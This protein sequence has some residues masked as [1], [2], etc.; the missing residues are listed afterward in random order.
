MN[1][2]L[3]CTFTTIDSVFY[4]VKTIKNTYK[5]DVAEIVV[6]GYNDNTANAVCIYNVSDKTKR[7]K[8]TISINKKKE[9]NTFY[10]INALNALIMA[11]NNGVLD[12]SYRINWSDYT[13]SILLSNNKTSYRHIQITQINTF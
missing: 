13:N 5:Q 9:T 6:Y 7:L 11:L 1:A 3:L 4:T 2:Q 10:S 12:K 8:D